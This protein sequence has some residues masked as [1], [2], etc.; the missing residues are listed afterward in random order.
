MILKGKSDRLDEDEGARCMRDD[1]VK[2]RFV[3]MA[4]IANVFELRVTG[5]FDL[6]D[7]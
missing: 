6:F 7:G 2:E 5:L 1:S 4:D 3:L